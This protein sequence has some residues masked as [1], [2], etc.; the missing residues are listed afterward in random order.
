MKLLRVQKSSRPGKKYMALFDVKGRNKTVHFGASDYEDYTQHHDKKRR[1]SYRARHKGDN[2]NDPT[3]PGS[4][5]YY[6]LWG[7]S[8]SMKSNI[9]MYRKR[10]NI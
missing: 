3:S 6:I 9:A 4:L 10:F 7:E 2:L 1:Q 8:T 5:S